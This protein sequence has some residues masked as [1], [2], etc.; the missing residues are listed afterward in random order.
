MPKTPHSTG[1]EGNR[2]RKLAWIALVAGLAVA[3]GAGAEEATT[4]TL[5]L[6]AAER[7]PEDEALD[8]LADDAILPAEQRARLQALSNAHPDSAD[9]W[10]AYGE[11]LARAREGELAL[12]ALERAVRLDPKLYSPWYWIGIV[13]KRGAPSPD[14]ERAE[15]AFME[16]IKNGAPR[17]ATL[18][19]LG[20][21]R[22]MQG[23]FKESVEAWRAAIEDDPQWG[24]LYSNL[25]KAAL[26]SGEEKLVAR[27]IDG[28]IAAQ[29]FEESA[30][31]IYGEHL[32][33]S[34][35]GA[36]A[37]EV[38][39][40]AIAAHP[41]RPRLRYYRGLAL[42]AAKKRPEA[43]AALLEAQAMAAAPET[44]DREILQAAEWE[45]F[46]LRNPGDEKDFQK[47]RELVFAQEE[48][49]SRREKNLKRAI[50]S[51]TK[52]AAKHP[53]FWNAYFA[54]GVAYR[55]LDDRASARADLGKVLSIRSDEPN[56][57]MELALMDRD[58]YR[59]EEAANG[60]EAAVRLAP[61]DPMF[62]INAGLI[63]LEA[64]RCERAWE[65]YR[66][67]IRMVGEENAAVLRVEL[68]ARCAG[69]ESTRE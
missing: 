14:L 6:A 10:A 55:R 36:D 16:A 67:A 41:D 51:L 66:A 22:A 54:R 19:E 45:L 3:A 57:T 4:P 11:C 8:I 44:S 65:L 27:L 13:Y 60:A 39:R 37:A 40:R 48:S 24:V 56:A 69:K 58:D 61:R 12:A 17:P 2:L 33:Q 20:V 32:V 28:A 23:K 52:L 1:G 35:K 29:R 50:E 31:M 38:Y 34:G 21:T 47:A 30:V 9:I 15:A 62:A 42:A 63:M 26:R 53:D 5:E 46:R 49:A 68:D 59:F 25:F 18:N 43:E 64:G 7:T